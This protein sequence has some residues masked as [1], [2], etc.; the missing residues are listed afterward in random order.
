MEKIYI[1]LSDANY[2]KV[3]LDRAVNRTGKTKGTGIRVVGKSGQ[4]P[5]IFLK[6][7]PGTIFGLKMLYG[8]SVE[9]M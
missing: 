7:E 8:R 2:A 1:F 4:R 9:I 5:P 6:K 3:A